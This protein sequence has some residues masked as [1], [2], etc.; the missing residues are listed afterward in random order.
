MREEGGKVREEGGKGIRKRNEIVQREE[1]KVGVKMQN[2]RIAGGE[3]WGELMY[4]NR[5]CVR[6]LHGLARLH[7]PC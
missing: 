6:E 2:V 4:K 5:E 1:A 7:L 3:G